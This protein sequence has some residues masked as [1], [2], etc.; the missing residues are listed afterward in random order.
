MDIIN[1]VNELPVHPKEKYRTRKLTDIKRIVVHH[2]ATGSNAT[3]RAFASYH[4]DNNKWPGI[5]YHYVVSRDGVIY[6]TNNDST[7]SWHA[8]PTANRDSIGIC[9]V[10]TFDNSKPPA[11]QWQAAIDL[12]RHLMKAYSVPAEGVIGHCEVPK[13]A[14][15]CPGRAIDLKELRQLVK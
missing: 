6:K 13:V 10:G 2:S 15:S 4:V 9:M 3:P 1:I 11:A 14:K 12:I 8:G 5:G 7:V